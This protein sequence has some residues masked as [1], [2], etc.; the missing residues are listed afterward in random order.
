MS[1]RLS[2]VIWPGLDV[3]HRGE[4]EDLLNPAVVHAFQD[5]LGALPLHASQ[6][7]VRIQDPVYVIDHLEFSLIAPVFAHFAPPIVSIIEVRLYL[8]LIGE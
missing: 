7:R 6:V 3:E 8:P 1:S 5:A 2:L 4:E